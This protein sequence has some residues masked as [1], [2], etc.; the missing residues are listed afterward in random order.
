MMAS[1]TEEEPHTANFRLGVEGG[2][3]EL[4]HNLRFSMAH[5]R[6]ASGRKSS[7]KED[8]DPA[9]DLGF[10]DREVI[11]DLDDYAAWNDDENMSGIIGIQRVDSKDVVFENRAK[12]VKI[13]GRY[14][15]GDVLGEGSYAKVKEAI[16]KETLCRRAVKIMKRKKLRRI[17]H[18][19]ENVQK[20]IQL[21]GGLESHQRH[22]TG[23]SLVQRRKG[24]NLHGNGILLCRAQRHAGPIPR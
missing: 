23:R 24:K 14:V 21:L 2:S 13:L 6:N 16:D 18:G 15:M 4:L 12:K 17:P 22:E 11:G 3:P 19:E 5:S 9:D 8:N 20:E 10:D 1:G 7:E